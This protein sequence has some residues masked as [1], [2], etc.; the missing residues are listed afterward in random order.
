MK[1]RHLITL[2]RPSVLKNINFKVY[3]LFFLKSILIENPDYIEDIGK[4]I[5]ELTS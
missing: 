4:G 3:F 2:N 1:K 5:G